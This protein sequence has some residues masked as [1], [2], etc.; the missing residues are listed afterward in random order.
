MATLRNLSSLNTE[1][2]EL[3]NQRH[4]TPE[5]AAAIDDRI[6]MLECLIEDRI[7]ELK[8]QAWEDAN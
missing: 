3:R 8:Q 5:E 7:Y 2:N 1:L 6:D 4:L